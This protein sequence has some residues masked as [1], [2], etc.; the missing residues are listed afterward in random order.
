MAKD[1]PNEWSSTFAEIGNRL[2]LHYKQDSQNIV[3][4]DTNDI[5]L[6]DPTVR[7]DSFHF[8]IRFAQN[9][10]KALSSG[11]F[12]ELN[13]LCDAQGRLMARYGYSL[14]DVVRRSA[15]CIESMVQVALEEVEN[16]PN[17]TA[18]PRFFHAFINQ[19]NHLQSQLI[20]AIIAGYTE[21]QESGVVWPFV[22]PNEPAPNYKLDIDT[23][24]NQINA[25]TGEYTVARYRSGATI[26]HDAEPQR[27]RFYFIREG[28]IQL[29]EFLA[30]GR[31]LTLTILGKGD[32]FARFVNTIPGN[33]FRDFQ[34]E[35]MRDTEMIVIEEA[36]LERAMQRSP[37]V[38]ASI[39]RSF[40][41]QLASV[42]R[43]IQGLLGRDVSVRLAHLLLKL[44][45]QFG[46]KQANNIILINYSLSHQQLADMMGSNRVTV[47]RQL[48]D[49]QKMGYLEIKR[50]SITIYNRPA[51]EK[52]AFA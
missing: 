18:N 35:A 17:Y 29:Q 27:S 47:T 48:S 4:G 38:A 19:L 45:D 21:Q 5:L 12:D 39:I 20:V 37:V 42:H 10:A 40:S 30:D 43:L 24:L 46:S 36:A 51:L 49:L 8:H 41:L 14:A 6:A 23:V 33:Y 32:V 2:T 3:K 22:M 52:L 9:F 25:I 11:Q 31:A 34:A 44:A 1:K 13:K 7:A 16:D 15:S 28:T 26:F 50:R